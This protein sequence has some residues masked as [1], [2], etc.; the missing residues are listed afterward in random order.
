M[1]AHH[2]IERAASHSRYLARLLA[3]DT[4]F[5]GRLAAGL[6]QPFDADTMQAQLLA[7]APD[8]EAALNTALRKLR[9]DVLARLIV[10]DLGGLADLPEIMGACTDLAETTLRCALAHHS[11]WLALKHG[12]PKNPDGSDMQLVIVGMGKLGGRELNVS[13]DIDLIYL[14]PQEGET[15]GAKPLSH[16]EFF[17]LLG[18]KLGLAISDLTADGFVFRVDTRL[19]PW[20]DA[21]PLAMSYA[22]LEDY[23]VT[24]GREWERYA[25]IKGRALTGTRLDELDQIIRPFVFRKY[26]DF[27]AF[28]AMR[29]LHAQ[30]RREV[31]RRDRADNIK[32]GPGG[33]REIE[34]IAQVFQLIRGGQVPDLQTRS[35][36]TALPLLAARGLLPE[37]AVTQL[38]AAYVFLRNLEH[39]LQYLDDAQTQTLPVQ[40]DD[41]LRIATSMGFA[42]YPAFLD[43]LN[44][45]R[46]HVSR[47]FD[48]VFAAP[49]TD[50]SSHPLAG[51]W[52][53]ALED[54]DALATLAELG[55]SAP[56]EVC[57]RLRQIRSSTRYTT[58]PASNRARFD[59]LMP[60]LIE[61]AAGC[62]PPD[63]TLTRILDLLET[64]ARRDSYLAL[65]VE[66]PAT[67]QRV[68][69]LCSASPWAAQFLA[70]N[71]ML[72]DELLDTR[73][74]YAAQDWAAL[75]KEL[76]ALM[77]THNGDTERQMDAM[78]Q[79]RQRVTFHLLAQDLAGVLT[80][81][82]LSDH[83]SDLAALILSA[84]LP[85]AWAGVRYRHRDTPTFAIIGYGKLGGR[86]MGYASDLDLV[87][88][89][90]DPAPAA[91]EHYAR[92]AQRINTWLGSTTA[93]GVLYE[94]DLRLRPDGASGLL[95]SSIEAFSQ[96][97]H[98]H[99]W[100][101]EHQA[102]TRA[103]HVAGDADVGARF[104]RIRCDILTQ[105][106][107]TAKLREDVL[108]MRQKMHDG[109][110]NHSA[111]FDLK[112]D[113]GG[114]V[115]VEFMV[116]YL[117]LAHAAHHPELTRN[118]GNIA[119]L[120]LAAELKLISDHDAE[121][122]RSAYR[123]FRR[124]QHAL[125]LQSAQT[126]RIEL[127]QVADHAAAVKQL[128]RMLFA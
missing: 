72:L 37:S 109:H 99:A 32:L 83:L 63:A 111:L 123:E 12:M 124:L 110:P 75:R 125:R 90:D 60:A 105:P 13:S 70:R 128:W 81:E 102:L 23:L 38:L 39:R 27:N 88:L 30:I 126:A 82:A 80:L 41:H 42:D 22:A 119:L 25:W 84:T 107:D 114:I 116:Q 121:A 73:V 113:A 91:A 7:A 66:Y 53:G 101:W 98:S 94:T 5:A 44:T 26:L 65:L 11:A 51:L 48:Q 64:V 92:L 28:A 2:L 1:P 122:V 15:G 74:L 59:T 93:A 52:Q 8:D 4:Q 47:H 34:F 115:D 58:L 120:K 18:K 100:T 49:Q 89:Y 55:Y 104:E 33:I 95:V 67:L 87:F 16:H 76:Q 29:D 20:G 56:A 43:A 9:Q 54:V 117:V 31:V 86:E 62:N 108:V 85:L 127:K 14:Y 77:D 71:P 6:A 96:Y 118:S 106:R 69:T 97:Q 19:R 46:H 103:R 45:H 57:N 79:F 68:A 36:L 112:H 78:R 10:R 50:E 17:V 35:L 24:H 21:G 40:P 3:A 61:V